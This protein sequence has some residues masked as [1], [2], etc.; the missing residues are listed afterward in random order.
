MPWRHQPG[1]FA[2]GKSSGN[3]SNVATQ[4]HKAC[5]NCSSIVGF[6][7]RLFFR[8]GSHRSISN[9]A[10]ALDPKSTNNCGVELKTLAFNNWYNRD[11]DTCGCASPSSS[12]SSSA[13]PD[14]FP[15]RSTTQKEG[16]GCGH[17]HPCSHLTPVRALWTTSPATSAKTTITIKCTKRTCWNT[18]KT[19]CQ[20]RVS[21]S[22]MSTFHSGCRS[23]RW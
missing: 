10:A 8:A 1:R 21:V 16:E 3:A 5:V 14:L 17:V 6:P 15:T 18:T 4:L 23:R 7:T 19:N 12:S 9:W 22:K 13:N 2:R 11:C 20:L